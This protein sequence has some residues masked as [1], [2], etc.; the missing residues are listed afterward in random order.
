MRRFSILVF[1]IVVLAA[2]IDVVRPRT[3]LR[4][5]ADVL[6]EEI[7]KVPLCSYTDRLYGFTVR[8]LACFRPERSGGPECA[9]RARFRHDSWTSIVLECYVTRAVAVDN[10][11]VCD[12]RCLARRLHARAKAAGGGGYVMSG[13][14]YED[15][16]RVPG[17]GHYTKCV[18]NGKLW[19]CYALTYPEEYKASLGRLFAL[20][21]RWQPWPGQAVMTSDRA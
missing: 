8:Y 16:S 11:E 4:S 14:L 19:F 6:L 15:G 18:R 7:N 20:V 12:W 17:Y 2:L 1:S 3:R 21:E 9:G 5:F 10:T 13:P